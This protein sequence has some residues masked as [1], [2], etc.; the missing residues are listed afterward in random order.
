MNDRNRFGPP[1]ITP[2][3]PLCDRWFPVWQRQPSPSLRLICFPYAGG[4][5]GAFA[6]WAC[7]L[8]PTVEVRALQLPGRASRYGESPVVGVGA[9]LDA[10]EPHMRWLAQA[11]YALFGHSLGGIVAFELA[12]RLRRLG[13]HPPRHLFVSSACVPERIG[14]IDPLHQ[15]PDGEFVAQLRDLGG[16]PE[17]V[18]AHPELMAIVLPSLRADFRVLERW[19][20][21]VEPPLSIPVTVLGGRADRRVPPAELWHWRRH[22]GGPFAVRLFDGDHFYLNPGRGALMTVIRDALV[23]SWQQ[24]EVQLP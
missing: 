3:S 14:E 7:D 5:A 2:F 11:P 17:E 1:N 23:D 13:V 12:R 6:T 18:F 16:T 9:L 22:A 21:P 10:I 4:Q 8:G 15:L 24:G 19:K 20:T